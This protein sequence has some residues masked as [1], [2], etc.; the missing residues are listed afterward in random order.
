METRPTSMGEFFDYRVSGYEDHMRHTINSFDSFY[1][2]ISLPIE[3]TSAQIQI[4][5]LGCGTGLEFPHL[6]EKAPNA[7]ITGID[8]SSGM[9]AKLEQ[10]Y[11]EYKDQIKLI[12]ASFLEVDLGSRRFDYALSVMSMHH[13][14]HDFKLDLYKRIH[15]SLRPGGKYI[16]GDYIVSKEE[17][18]SFLAEFAEKMERFGLPLDQLFHVDIPFHSTGSVNL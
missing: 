1:E 15:R 10:K 5:D 3:R 7:V 2:H 14:V 13:L 6:L 17:E 4:L 9:L 12:T 16:E 11:A 18:Q 8:V